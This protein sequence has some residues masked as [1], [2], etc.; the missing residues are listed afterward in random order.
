MYFHIGIVLFKQ[1]ITHGPLMVRLDNVGL[2]L[3]DAYLNGLGLTT[4]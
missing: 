1:A 3:C 4:F 2:H